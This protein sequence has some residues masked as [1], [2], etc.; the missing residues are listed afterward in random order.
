MIH[1]KNFAL[2][3]AALAA[4]LLLAT[5][6]HAASWVDITNPPTSGFPV[7]SGS[8]SY[9][10]LA[11]DEVWVFDGA[12]PGGGQSAAAIANLIDTQFGL[13]SSGAG[14]ITLS[15]SNDSLSGAKSGSFTVST[16]FNYLAVHYGQGE[17]LFYWDQAV[18]AGSVFT[19]SNLPHGISNFRAYDAV[20]AAVPEPATYA[21][22]LGGLGLVG[23]AARRRKA[24]A[25]K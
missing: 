3:L 10:S 19:F 4:T 21:M 23:F 13:P 1:H 8:V 24:Q 14:S 6:A 7:G 22:L 25:P 5:A 16:S 20:A 2:K 18:P 12:N 15:S 9:G 11:A 17:L